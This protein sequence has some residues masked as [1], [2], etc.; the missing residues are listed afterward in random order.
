M[1]HFALTGHYFLISKYRYTFTNNWGTGSI[2][3]K[4]IIHFLEK[5]YLEKQYETRE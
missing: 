2:Y 1:A 5:E 3:V 4:I